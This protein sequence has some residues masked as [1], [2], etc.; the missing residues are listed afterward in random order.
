M[1]NLSQMLLRHKQEIEELQNCCSHIDVSDWMPFMWAPGHY[2]GEV[3]VCNFC[4]RAIEKRPDSI[5]HAARE[6]G[7]YPQIDSDGFKEVF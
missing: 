1:E 2:A 3:R 5:H 6:E 4:G 7:E